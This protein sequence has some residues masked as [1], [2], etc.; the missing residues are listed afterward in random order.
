MS[1]E[2]FITFGTGYVEHPTDAYSTHPQGMF[3]TGYATMVAEDREVGVRLAHAV[4]NGR[5]AFDYPEKPRED[6]VP[7]GELLRVVVLQRGQLTEASALLDA[8][9]GEAVGGSTDDELEALHA[10]REMLADIVGYRS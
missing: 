9:Y 6:Y 7:D 5:Y 3:G 1:T 10:V 4:F 8:A 2:T